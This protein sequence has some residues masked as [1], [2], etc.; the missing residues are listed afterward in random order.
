MTDLAQASPLILL[1]AAL[2][3]VG[4]AALVLW[5]VHAW[6]PLLLVAFV[7]GAFAAPVLAVHA[8][9]ALLVRAPVLTPV[10]LAPLVEEVAKA[11][12]L[13]LLFVVADGG[14]RSGIACGA[15]AGLGFSLTENVGYLT[16]AA[17]QDGP[18]GVWRA[19]W[20]RGIVGG[21]KHPVFTATTGAA[22]GRVRAMPAGAARTGVGIAGLGG[23]VLQHAVWNGV[24]SRAITDVMCHAASAGGPCQGPDTVDLLVRIPARILACIAPGLFG[25]AIV[26]HRAG[27]AA[28]ADLPP[29]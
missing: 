27:R 20:L 11:L 10:V 15:L 3:V 23:A 9:D 14:V 5:R 16:L 24:V 19:I 22:L 1:G 7:W 26:A 21:A 18:A 28:G 17:V 29:S 13:G 6:R 12:V 25:L 2:P 4:F 8:N